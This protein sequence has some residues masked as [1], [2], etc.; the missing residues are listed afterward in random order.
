MRD[1]RK[2]A[3]IWPIAEEVL[4][5]GGCFRLFPSGRSML[6]LLR[7]GRDSVLLLPPT[8]LRRYDILL[9]RAPNGRFLL[10]RA[11]ALDGESVTLAGDA[12]LE[13]EGPFP[14]SC[15]LSRVGTV[16]RDEKEYDPRSRRAQLAARLRALRR[17][18]LAPLVRLRSKTKRNG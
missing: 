4:R 3:E 6:P 10:H 5:A 2:M 8:D 14:L 1:V 7:E 11:I 15:V 18:L 13:T 12:L 9:V 16:Y 17:R